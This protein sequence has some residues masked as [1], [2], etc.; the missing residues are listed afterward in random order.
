MRIFHGI[1]YEDEEDVHVVSLLS[2]AN[3]DFN[4]TNEAFGVSV[5]LYINN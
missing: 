4:W 1:E 3:T 2:D 5:I